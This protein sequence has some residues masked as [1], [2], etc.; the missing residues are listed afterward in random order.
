MV[1]ESL[2]CYSGDIF[3]ELKIEVHG[4]LLQPHKLGF[5]TINNSTFQFDTVPIVC[6]CV[7]SES[8]RYIETEILSVCVCSCAHAFVRER[9][10][11]RE[12]VNLCSNP[13]C[14]VQMYQ[15][16]KSLKPSF[17]SISVCL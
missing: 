16:Q 6:V 11:E 3:S 8:N 10:I 13:S 17:D 9:E 4:C 14:N 1:S 12:A 7:R 15:H 5:I 2:P